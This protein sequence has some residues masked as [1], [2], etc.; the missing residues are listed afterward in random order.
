MFWIICAALLLIVAVAILAPV[1]RQRGDNGETAPAASFDM[2]VYRDQMQEVERDLERGVIAPDEAERL[3]TEIGRKILDADR[4][5]ADAPTQRKGGAVI[6]AITVMAIISGGAVAL[7]LR[8]G[9]PGMPDLPIAERIAQAQRAYDERP[10]QATAESQA[11]ARAPV[12]EAEADPE[13]LDLVEQLRRA[14]AEKP[15]DPQ[16]LTLL[17]N[18]EMRLGNI[19]AARDAQQ[20][21]VDLRQDEASAQELMQL[22]ALMMEAAGGL[23][24]PQAE[25]VLARS[26]QK[27]PSQPQA[28]Y[29]LGMLQLQNGRPDRAFPIWRDLLEAGPEDAPWIGPIRNSIPDLAW[30]A[31]EPNYQPPAPAAGSMPT[32]PGPDQDSIAA[33]RDLSPE[34]RQDMI[35]NMVSQ[36]ETRLAE[37]GG[38]PQEW[39]RLISSL[40]ILGQTD[41]ARDIW[42]EAQL[43]FAASAEALAPIRAAAQ[44]AGLLE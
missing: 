7:Y 2:K 3:R 9:A 8:E 10:D 4:R 37:E 12:T 32:L 44:D 14:V 20:K 15:D 19:P 18:S 5:M 40:V 26:L 24:T 21:L 30:L 16:G 39:A 33:A 13:Y 6:A 31:G 41:H 17:A 34:E 22:A 35:Q 11:P 25:E 36:L 23:I 1:W 43:R 42:G 29:L 28:R 38:T 27:D